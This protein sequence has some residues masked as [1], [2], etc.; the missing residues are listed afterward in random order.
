MTFASSGPEGSKY[1]CK[2]AAEGVFK[3]KWG[4]PEEQENSKHYRESEVWDR[5]TYTTSAFLG[6]A[7]SLEEILV[8][9]KQSE[10]T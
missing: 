7:R 10:G 5:K 1:V 2:S 8:S 3:Y 6:V 9:T 4:T